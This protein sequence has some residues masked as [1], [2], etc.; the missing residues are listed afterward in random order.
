MYNCILKFILYG[1]KIRQTF[2]LETEALEAY[3][4]SDGIII[5]KLFALMYIYVYALNIIQ[6]FIVQSIQ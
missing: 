1:G 6:Y 2:A 3:R 5:M 4:I